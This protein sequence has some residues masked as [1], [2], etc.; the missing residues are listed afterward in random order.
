MGHE[1][2]VTTVGEMSATELKSKLDRG[3][4]VFILDVREP[5]EYRI[6]QIPGS[7]LIPLD[8]LPQRVR[9]IDGAREI[10]VHCKTGA[11]SARAVEFLRGAGSGVCATSN[12]ASSAGSRASTPASRCTDHAPSLEKAVDPDSSASAR[13]IAERYRIP[14]ELLAKILQ[15]LVRRGL[16]QS[17][18]GIRGGYQLARNPSSISVLEVIQA[19]DGPLSLTT[20]SSSDH[21]CAQF[22]WCNVRDPLRQVRDRIGQALKTFSIF[23]LTTERLAEDV[24]IRQ[25][26][27][28][29][30]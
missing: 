26:G 11:R 17:H 7:V 8:D 6:H 9:E 24:S 13:S 2:E 14:L 28:R 22:R 1:V 21:R 16:L 20:C 18:H 4:Q 27:S 12:A 15:K 10:V 30:K 23:D 3:E 25:A 19:I 29:R 5:Q